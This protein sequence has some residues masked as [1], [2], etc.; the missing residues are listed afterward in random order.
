[1]HT[2]RSITGAI[3]LVVLFVLQSTSQII[4]S[5][6]NSLVLE[7][8]SDEVEWVRFDLRDD[9]YHDAVGVYDDTVSK[10]TRPVHAD[11]IIGIYDEN[12]LNLARPIAVQYL[13]PRFDLSMLLISDQ[14]NLLEARAAISDI[15]GLEI[16]EY[17]SPSGLIV[18]GTSYA[19]RQASLL[20]HVSSFH[21]VPV[22]LI[23]EPDLLDV[24]MLEGGEESLL[25]QRI[26]LEGWRGDNGLEASV[27]FRGRFIAR[28]HYPMEYWQI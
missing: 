21:D 3:F 2:K 19:L 6:E 5:N 22:A 4:H 10:E 28:Q 15:A 14:Y 27:S 8:Q 12:G 1:M 23:I 26:R 18:Q 9:V 16:R 7:S 13:E 17:I 11:T 20:P 24:L 25:G